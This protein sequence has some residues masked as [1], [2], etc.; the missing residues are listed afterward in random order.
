MLQTDT[1][2][3][4]TYIN[5]IIKLKLLILRR[6][7]EQRNPL[8]FV[9]YRCCCHFCSWIW[10]ST[11]LITEIIMVMLTALRA[12]LGSRC[13][14]SS[15]EPRHSAKCQPPPRVCRSVC[16]YVCRR[17]RWLEIEESWPQ[18][19]KETHKHTPSKHAHL[20]ALTHTHADSELRY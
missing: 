20:H 5:A 8:S 1:A 19:R 4:E 16:M 7:G 14:R 11:R 9:F 12:F 17:E 2:I 3:P 10:S 6:K 15:R 13:Q 18:V